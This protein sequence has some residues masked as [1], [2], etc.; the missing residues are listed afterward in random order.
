MARSAGN[1]LATLGF[2]A[3]TVFW[4]AF[5]HLL[6]HPFSFV[7]RKK[8]NWSLKPRSTANSA[9][10]A[11]KEGL[12]LNIF[13]SAQRQNKPQDEVQEVPY[14]LHNGCNW[15]REWLG[16]FYKLCGF[17]LAA[18][19]LS[20]VAQPIYCWINS[21][22]KWLKRWV[23]N[24]LVVWGGYNYSA[25]TSLF[26]NCTS[27]TEI[28]GNVTNLY[29]E[30]RAERLYIDAVTSSPSIKVTTNN[31]WHFMTFAFDGTKV[32]YSWSY[33]HFT[34]KKMKTEVPTVPQLVSTPANPKFLAH[35]GAPMTKW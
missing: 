7:Y 33:T 12:R 28:G 2:N 5:K 31:A 11:W 34:E 26:I 35:P 27:L 6:L 30:G 25:C 9:S 8:Q 22:H 18:G 10:S 17:H 1:I 3:Q 21:D 16:E 19:S 29:E 14:L 15:E 20:V 4:L 32:E 23:S 13:M 24:L